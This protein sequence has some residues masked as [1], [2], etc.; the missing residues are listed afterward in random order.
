MGLVFRL[1]AFFFAAALSAQISFFPLR[2]VRA[3]MKGVGRTVFAGNRIEEFQVEIL[4]VLENIGPKQSLILARL[5][6]RPGSHRRAAGHERQPGLHRRQAARRG[7]HGVSLSPRSPSPASAPSRR[8][9]AWPSAGAGA[10]ARAPRHSLADR[11]LTAGCPTAG[12]GSG[13]ARLVDIATPVSFGGFTRARVEQFAPQL[14][15]LGLEPR[16]GVS[17]GGTRRRAHGRLR[18]PSKPGSMIS[19]Q[20]LTGDMSI[21]ADGTVTHIDGHRVY[22]FGHRFL[23][24]GATELPFARAE[25]L[26]LLPTLSTSFKISTAREMMGTIT[27]DRNTAVAGELGRRARP[28]ASPDLASRRAAA[29]RC[30]TLSTCRW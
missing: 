25:V 14:R 4:G 1:A 15:A 5:S 26:T 10:A 8:C 30:D 6:G 16:Q 21:G 3:G 22:A 7:G 9:C 19:V 17:G 13:D 24:V 29:R 28:H 12:G 27:E 2:D 20:L 11:D 18:A 23:G